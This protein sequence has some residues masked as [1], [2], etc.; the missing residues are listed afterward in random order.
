MVWV[1]SEKRGTLRGKKGDLNENTREKEERKAK[2]KMV[3]KSEG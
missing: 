1:C 2:E 3:G